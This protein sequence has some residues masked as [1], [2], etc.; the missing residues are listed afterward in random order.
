MG[1]TASAFQL[2]RCPSCNSLRSVSSRHARRKPESC[3]SCKRV[4]E[5]PKGAYQAFWLKRFSDDE[6]CL[7]AEAIFNR[8]RGSAD[9]AVVASARIRTTE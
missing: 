5:E 1:R 8:P 9:P 7:M 2:V 6:I 3:R 4:R